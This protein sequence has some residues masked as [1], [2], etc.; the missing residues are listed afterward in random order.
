M[1][2]QSQDGQQAYRNEVWLVMHKFDNPEDETA[3]LRIYMD[4]SGDE[5]PSLSGHP[6]PATCGHLKTG[7]L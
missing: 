2:C 7:H 3:L 5:S 4:E 1:V 6:K